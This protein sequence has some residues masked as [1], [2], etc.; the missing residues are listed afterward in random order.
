M[1]GVY[2]EMVLVEGDSLFKALGYAT[3]GRYVHPQTVSTFENKIL[4]LFI[5]DFR[6]N[7]TLH[8]GRGN[9]APTRGWFLQSL[10]CLFNY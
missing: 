9:L 8:S 2:L 3:S 6:I 5:V 1:T 10:R 4:G 7:E